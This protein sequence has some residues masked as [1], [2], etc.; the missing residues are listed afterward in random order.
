VGCHRAARALLRRGAEFDPDGDP[1]TD[2]LA[3][4]VAGSHPL[5]VAEILAV[6]DNTPRLSARLCGMR[7]GRAQRT[8]LHVAAARH[9]AGVLR[10]LLLGKG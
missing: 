1:C 2:A 9:C 8:L 10:L 5:C 4:S 3:L 7:R 6:A